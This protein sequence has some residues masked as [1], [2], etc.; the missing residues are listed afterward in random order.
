MGWSDASC[1]GGAR[2]PVAAGMQLLPP[3]APLQLGPL[4]PAATA[5]GPGQPPLQSMTPN[6]WGVVPPGHVPQVPPPMWPHLNGGPGSG[7]APLHRQP[8]AHAAA[9]ISML[10]QQPAGV[11]RTAEGAAYTS[12]N[13]IAAA[14][15][16]A[17]DSAPAAGSGSHRFQ[18]Q[19]V[20]QGSGEDAP[21]AAALLPVADEQQAP[22]G[23]TAPKEGT[24]VEQLPLAGAQQPDLAQPAHAAA[25]ADAV[26]ATQE[27]ESAA[28]ETCAG[29]AQLSSKPEEAVTGTSIVETAPAAAAPEQA[30]AGNQPEPR[31]AVSVEDAASGPAMSMAI[32]DSVTVPPDADTG[33]APPNIEQE[34]APTAAASSEAPAV[35]GS[36]AAAAEPQR[37]LPAPPPDDAQ[38][39]LENQSQLA[40]DAGAALIGV[41]REGA[42]TG[43]SE[44]RS[45]QEQTPLAADAGAALVGDIRAAGCSEEAREQASASPAIE[46]AQPS[47][48]HA[49]AAAPPSGVGQGS[50]ST[51]PDANWASAEQ[52]GNQLTADLTPQPEKP[53]S[54]RLF[55]PTAVL[56]NGFA[57]PAS[58]AITPPS[59]CLVDPMRSAAVRPG[60]PAAVPPPL[61]PAAQD[62]EAD[63]DEAELWGSLLVDSPSPC[64]TAKVVWT[65]DAGLWR[66]NG[67]GPAPPSLGQ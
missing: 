4:T 17:Q 5:H 25:A 61:P 3:P 10:A 50:A 16:S 35:A 23:N 60:A 11:A 29:N 28:A 58:D 27:P 30:D 39:P 46:P 2:R 14:A 47:Q 13:G 56:S 26:P 59:K 64:K 41:I 1:A 19:A 9:S 67:S 21:V 33:A 36:V 34:A 62:V 12:W 57:S 63:A 53:T 40:A 20:A 31:Q 32:Q 22:V 38:Q 55:D 54:Q 65:Q 66:P 6:F 7:P 44:G 24:P 51:A 42:A 48:L 45:E 43:P 18:P 8:I 15:P 49:T 52:L 37:N